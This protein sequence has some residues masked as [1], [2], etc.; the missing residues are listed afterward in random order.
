MA[1]FVSSFNEGVQTGSGMVSRAQAQQLQQRQ[2]EGQQALMR[3]QQQRFLLD[4]QKQA[5]EIQQMVQNQHYEVQ[6]NHAFLQLG[7]M[8]K[9]ADLTDPRT[10]IAVFQALS[11]VP[12]A[13]ADPR[14]KAITEMLS[15]AKM[16]KQNAAKHQLEIDKAEADRQYKTDTIELRRQDQFLSQQKQSFTEDIGNRRFQFDVTRE[17]LNAQ[18]REDRFALDATV[19]ASQM[20]NREDRFA[21]DATKAA[22]DLQTAQERM[23]LEREK[24]QNQTGQVIETFNPDGTVATR[25][26][27]GGRG[28]AKDPNAP[29][30]GTRTNL[31]GKMMGGREAL[32]AGQRLKQLVT[33]D[34]VG[35]KG[36]FNRFVAEWGGQIPGLAESIAKNPKMEDAEK[37]VSAMLRYQS[38]VVKAMRTD[39]QISNAERLKWEGAGPTIRLSDSVKTAGDRLQETQTAIV[40]SLRRSALELGRP[41]PPEGMYPSE[42]LQQYEGG[43]MDFKELSEALKVSPFDQEVQTVLKR[44]RELATQNARP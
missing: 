3:L 12:M 30:T 17:A 15:G 5:I 27:Q 39:P 37:Y 10:D 20:Q 6:R 8:L 9:D 33:P 24:M 13:S 31:E 36:A 42:L 1:D 38:H 25:F 28:A 32:A 26:T 34:T 40:D 18:H 43:R 35:V 21:L 11:K 2:L 29:T 22:T 23:D 16:M 19:Q 14:F 7:E 4:A 41:I 44:L